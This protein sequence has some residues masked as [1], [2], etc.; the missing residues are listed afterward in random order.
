MMMGTQGFVSGDELWG[1]D[2]YAPQIVKRSLFTGD[3]YSKKN[4]IVT[5]CTGKCSS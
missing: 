3:L 2:D 5:R 4:L 1:S